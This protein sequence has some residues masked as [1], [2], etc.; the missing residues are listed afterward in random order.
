MQLTSKIYT[1]IIGLYVTTLSL[2]PL[3]SPLGTC[4]PTASM[5]YMR[6]TDTAYENS[7]DGIPCRI[8]ETAME[9]R[10]RTSAHPGE[11]GVLIAATLSKTY[12]RLTIQHC[13][14]TNN[15]LRHTETV[16]F[17]S[18]S[19]MPALGQSRPRTLIIL[20]HFSCWSEI[21]MRIWDFCL[22]VCLSVRCWYSVEAVGL[23]ISS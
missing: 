20:S 11:T 4:P 18:L 19:Q 3:D 2:L 7:T 12:E 14:K 23:H 15:L 1:P 10:H 9:S 5:Q 17:D 13:H 16:A 6:Y 22:S 8:N 21:F